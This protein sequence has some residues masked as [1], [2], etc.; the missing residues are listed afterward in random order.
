M[1][2]LQQW[3]R[4]LSQQ[5]MP[6]FAHTAQ[7]IAQ[8]ARDADEGSAS[9]LAAKVLQDVSMTTRLLR[10]ANS[11]HF[12]PSG[13]K[14]NTVSRAI[15]LLGFNVVRDLCLSISLIDTVL[16]GPHREEAIEQMA[17]AFHAAM[18]A[19]RLA[20]LSRQA[21]PEEIF[22]ATLL[23]HLGDLALLC[24]ST[25]LD[26]PLRSRLRAARRSEAVA[27]DQVEREV[28]GFPVRELTAQLNR[29]W[30]L[31]PLLATA[32]DPTAA[33]T[34]RTQTLRF[35]NDLA[36]AMLAGPDDAR[37][38]ELLK[39]IAKRFELDRDAF[40]GQIWSTARAAAEAFTNLGAPAAARLIPLHDSSREPAATG[41]A[42]A[43]AAA[44]VE[45]GGDQHL[46]LSILRDISQ[47]L[48]ESR[49]SVN[50]LMD[51]VLEG[52]F[53]GLGMDRAIFALLSPDRRQ[54]RGKASLL[55]EG[56]ALP[57]PFEFALGPGE[58]NPFE[59][60]LRSG[61]PVWLGAPQASPPLSSLDARTR[62]LCGGHCFIMPLQV[63]STAIGCLYADRAHSGRALTEELFAQ[64][65]LFG[66]QARM[67]LS[68]IKTR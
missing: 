23:W 8:H 65:K 20:E 21:E 14:I 15:I 62:A 6:I 2:S 24:S 18:Q 3:V 26:E 58:H 9:D 53:R 34:D 30:R 7:S 49:P 29:E 68:F 28:L 25:V 27:K 38:Q 5:Q 1:P 39:R 19:R 66:Q 52:I 13:G 48:V 37:L 46:Q 54:L 47:L 45:Q 51:L 16:S 50:V 35:G 59:R 63:G 10:M 17:I 61:E 60:A 22:I 43:D 33:K 56:A 67:G 12:N 55:A 4:E 31:S 32:L 36:V 64:F 41:K 44:S 42:T 40:A 57:E 11:I